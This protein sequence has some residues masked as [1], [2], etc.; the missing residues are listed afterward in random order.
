MNKCDLNV[1]FSQ[2]LVR[3]W[4]MWSTRLI[5]TQKVKISWKSLSFYAF[6]KKHIFRKLTTD[7]ENRHK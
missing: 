2:V 6:L 4:R 5:N 1:I 3:I 7:L